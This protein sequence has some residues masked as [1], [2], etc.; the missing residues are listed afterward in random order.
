MHA[1]ACGATTTDASLVEILDLS[2]G[3]LRVRL[4]PQP[5]LDDELLL[6]LPL[7]HRCGAIRPCQVKGRIVRKEGPEFGLAF[8]GLRAS[9]FLQL[10]DFV[11]RRSSRG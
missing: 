3:G 10:R 4:D 8:D 11:W 5:Q 6:T 1:H 9:E 7:T 2:E